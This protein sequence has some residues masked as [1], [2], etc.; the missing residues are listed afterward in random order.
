M[1]TG[2]SMNPARSFGPAVWNW[3]WD[4]HWVYWAAPLLG[5]TLAALFYR[6]VFWKKNPKD[7]VVAPIVEETDINDK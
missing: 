3:N 5:S 2:A 7:E 6:S 1:G 4:S